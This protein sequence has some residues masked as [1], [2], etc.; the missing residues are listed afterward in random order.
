MCL[1]LTRQCSADVPWS[2][3]V[4][5]PSGPRRSLK[6]LGAKRLGGANAS[7]CTGPSHGRAQPHR[8]HRRLLRAVGDIREEAF[9]TNLALGWRTIGAAYWQ[10]LCE[11][12]IWGPYG[13]QP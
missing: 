7:K 5:G 3:L 1:V 12:L 9:V 2:L 8:Q 13:P 11:L 10:D 6:G 4:S